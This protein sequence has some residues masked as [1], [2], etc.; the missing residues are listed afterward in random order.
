MSPVPKQLAARVRKWEQRFA[1]HAKGLASAWRDSATLARE[2]GLSRVKMLSEAASLAV[3]GRMG[4][5]T[6]FH[7]R[8]FDPRLTAEAKRQYLSEAPGANRQLWSVLTPSRYGCLFDNKLIFNRYFTSFGLPLATVFGVFD[9]Q[10]GRTMDGESLRTEPELGA[11]IRRFRQEGFAFKPAE[12][13]RGH[14]VL[15]LTGSS[16]ADSD[17]FLT[18]A[19][20]R[21]DA[22][23]LVAAARNTAALETQA[24]GANL[25][26]FLIE[27]RIRPHPAMAELIGPT[28]CT[29]RVVTIVALDGSPRI[30][31]SVLKLQPKPLGVD[32]LMYGA[33]GCWVDPDTGA[34]GPGR[35][36]TSYGYTSVIPGTDRSFVG[37][38]LP[39]WE[40]VKEAA[41][42]AATAFP[43]AR[44]IGWDI[45]ISDRG[46]VVIEGNQ[47][48]S[49][50]LV[51]L[52]APYGL[53]RGDLKA[54]YD[55]LWKGSGG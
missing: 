54:L 8:F 2:H 31:A 36:R 43:W 21:Y 20:E 24:P 12:G 25:S 26:P 32:H 55:T 10:V 5:D 28:L 4:V 46:P 41:L 53:M 34:L 17:T 51:Q 50:S 38:R 33:L 14:L 1:R 47:K 13:M 45:G 11:F 18:L 6:Y 29:V 22:A 44:S 27:E 35:T 49:P 19:G 39:C 42:Q 15:I 16:P 48:W 23:A 9:P 3:Q 52:P 40:Q 37:Y 30:V 7:Y